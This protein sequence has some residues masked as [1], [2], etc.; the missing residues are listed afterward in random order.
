VL[1]EPI[2]KKLRWVQVADPAAADL[3]R[4]PDFLIVGPQ[5]TGTTWLH[6]HLRFHPQI[7]L[8]E[9]KELYFFSGLKDTATPRFGS[10]ELAD[11]LRHFREPAW[12]FG[13]KT[14]LCLWRY[15]EFYRPRVRGE[16][17]ASYAVLDRDVIEE[18]ALLR[19]DVRVILMIRNPVDRA[20]S[21]AKKDLVRNRGRRF[22][23]VTP[24]EFVDFFTSDYQRRCARY[25]DQHDHWAACLR[26][27]HLF[28]G[29]FD[30]IAARPHELLLE[31]MSFLGVR[32]ERRYVSE[33]VSEPV[34]P[35]GSSRIPAEH[36]RF[37]DELFA[38]DLDLLRQ[39]L[40][41]SW[42]DAS[43][44]GAEVGGRS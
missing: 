3:A 33:A 5:R 16:A 13:L 36:R 39:R 32:S 2:R 9:P 14:A 7:F 11:Y 30:D 28:V 44:S 18:I 6:A 10:R 25:V 8:S 1:A 43:G 29:R 40:G 22:D 37:L 35:T 21:H 42:E 4:F 31:V 34:N 41:L 12:R 19:P 24:R 38:P 20:W 27:G 23:D 26:P 15:R 17:T